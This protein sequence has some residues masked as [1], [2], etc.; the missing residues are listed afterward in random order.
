MSK[1]APRMIAAVRLLRRSVLSIPAALF[2][3]TCAVNVASAFSYTSYSVTEG[4]TISI[5]LPTK[6]T[7]TA[8]QIHLDG[9]TGGSLSTVLAWCLDIYHDLNVSSGYAA[10]APAANG[11]VGG[12]MAEGNAY[13]L[14]ASPSIL[15]GKHIYNNKNDISAATQVAI[16]SQF[17][18]TLSYSMSG[19]S[20]SQ[21]QLKSLVAWLE[22]HAASNVAFELLTP[23]NP[24]NQVLGTLPVPGP[25][26]GAGLP[27]LLFAS[28]A[29]LA[30]RRRKKQKAKLAALG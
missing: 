27:G 2:L 29:L 7:F 19:T 12:L 28:G 10:G 22:S 25:I 6:E 13:L 23:T 17:N 8:G 5:T 3:G 15:I 24:Y 4:E 1:I 11:I 18:P 21:T 26:V 9:V 16:W 30:L 20:L 14:Q